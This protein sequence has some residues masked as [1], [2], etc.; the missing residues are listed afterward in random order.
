MQ[1]RQQFHLDQ[2]KAAEYRARQQAQI[3][4]NTQHPPTSNPQQPTAPAPQQ[5][6]PATPIVSNQLMLPAS[7]H[8]SRPSQV[9]I[10]SSVQQPLPS[11]HIQASMN[12]PPSSN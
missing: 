12:Y 2:L 3:Y 10:P 5:Q 8:G 9:N 11:Q 4:F 6:Q 1:D 7:Q